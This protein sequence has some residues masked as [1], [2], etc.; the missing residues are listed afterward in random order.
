[1]AQYRIKANKY[2]LNFYVG[3]IAGV[4][5]G[6]I[7]AFTLIS[8][9]IDT[10]YE[11][12]A[13]L[14]NTILEKNAKLENLEKSINSKK[15]VLRDIEIVLLFDE[16]DIDDLEIMHIEKTVKEKYNILLGAEV[17]SIDPDII[18]LV[19]DKRILKMNGKEIQLHVNKL[20]LTEIL[21]LW[22]DAKVI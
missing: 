20:K 16:N 6:S 5:I 18:T 10:F 17:K 22:I 19:V 7:L 14:E 2:F 9:R 1:M 8:Y 13:A 11:K 12:I 4:L 15:F 3:L 21:K